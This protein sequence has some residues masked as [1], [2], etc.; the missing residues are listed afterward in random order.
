MCWRTCNS[1]NI[2]QYFLLGGKLN[3]MP[4]RTYEPEGGLHELVEKHG[5]AEAGGLST[6]NDP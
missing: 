6:R 3:S 4:W 1:A 5:D 2:D